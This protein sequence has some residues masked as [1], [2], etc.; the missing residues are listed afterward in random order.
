MLI[1]RSLM[2]KSQAA[3]LEGLPS[4]ASPA[5]VRTDVDPVDDD[6]RRLVR[7]ELAR[8]PDPASIRFVVPT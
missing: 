4:A 8:R 5:V 3:A 7:N 1:S 6:E 2:T